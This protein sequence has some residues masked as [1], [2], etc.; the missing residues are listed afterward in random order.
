[1]VGSNTCLESCVAF[2]TLVG[3]LRLVCFRSPAQPC[4]I[5]YWL[6]YGHLGP[7]PTFFSDLCRLHGLYEFSSWCNNWEALACKV[8]L[9]NMVCRIQLGSNLFVV[10]FCCS[11]D[12]RYLWAPG[13]VQNMRRVRERVLRSCA[14][15]LGLTNAGL[16]QHRR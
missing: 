3:A 8:H 1:M 7:S 12:G 2:W 9:T 5:S 11:G 15:E 16:F 10:T 14:S 6:G 13:Q 4:G